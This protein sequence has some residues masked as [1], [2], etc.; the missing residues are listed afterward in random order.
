ML[1]AWTNPNL[2]V[3]P[4]AG[5][6]ISIAFAFIYRMDNNK[7]WDDERGD[8][9]KQFVSWNNEQKKEREDSRSERERERQGWIDERIRR[10]GDYNRKDEEHRKLML[11]VTESHERSI[12]NLVETHE[13]VNQATCKSF[14]ASEN[15]KSKEYGTVLSALLALK[16]QRLES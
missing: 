10:E 1:E 13:K 15:L 11:L 12:K 6:V 2:Y 5:L 8:R 7:R 3:G 14:E 16:G 4:C 9:E